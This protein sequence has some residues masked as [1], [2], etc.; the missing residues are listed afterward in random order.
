MQQ[1]QTLDD[2]FSL[3]ESR[4]NLEKGL[5]LGNPNRVYR[6][7][8]MAALCDAFGHP[9]D[10]Y[11][12]VHLAGSKGK[13]STSAYIAALLNVA[14]RR[15]GIY[16]SPHLI[17]YRERFRIEGESFP[18]NLALKTA[19]SLLEKLPTLEATLPGEGGAT[20]F[21]LLTLFAFLL[22]REAGCDTAVM[23][24]G[25][26][27]RLDATNV[28]KKPEAI[29]FTPIEREHTEILG[30]RLAGI[31]AEKAGILKPGTP[32]W[33][34]AQVL[35]VRR[36]FLQ[37]TREAGVRL[38]K[39][40]SRLKRID[41][42]PRGES[43]DGSFI[44]QLNWKDGVEEKL[45]LI[46][47]GRVQAENAALALLAVRELEG[48]LRPGEDLAASGLNALA[49]VS[50][51]G[52]FQHIQS[53]PNPAIIIDGA[54]TA[55]SV[56]A[57]AEAFV[58]VTADAAWGPP[59]LLFG[60]VE[61]KD[62]RAMARILCGG[63]KP[64][65]REVI[66]ST[67]GTFKPSNPAELAETFRRTSADVTLIPDPDEAWN[68]VLSRSGGSRPVLVTGSFFMAGEIARISAGSSCGLRPD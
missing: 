59:I 67:P 25:L 6:L 33:S 47:G 24:T 38:T 35:P 7:D 48:G 9:Q 49:S 54:H 11:R 16:S 20:T 57:L 5:P 12:T 55:G 2:A 22:F 4:T 41:L 13:G 56:S 31:A 45:H 19:R 34:A 39:L 1:I 52:R 58:Q 46:M 60:S 50:L 42:L 27:G 62:H 44:W 32:V 26:G 28:I 30:N 53:N 15:V 10:S 21:E 64:F 17:D 65:F 68:T 3:F 37:K 14:G 61:G 63:R 8:R 40:Q 51:P 43:A 36:V 23:E 66:I 18:E 29:V